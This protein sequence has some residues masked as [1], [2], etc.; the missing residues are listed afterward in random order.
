MQCWL[1]KQRWSILS[2][3][4]GRKNI[5]SVEVSNSYR[6]GATNL[7]ERINDE[8]LLYG[9]IEA[10]LSFEELSNSNTWMHVKHQQK[11]AGK[12]LF[13]LHAL[14]M[15]MLVQRYK[16]SNKNFY[17]KILK[18]TLKVNWNNDIYA[19]R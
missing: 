19:D 18:V 3:E 2:G 1:I 9:N 4:L 6:K 15:L 17:E 12:E 7:Q 11:V 10:D 13:Y 8:K 16:I 14:H 5:Y